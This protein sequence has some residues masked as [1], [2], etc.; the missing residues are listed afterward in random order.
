MHLVLRSEIQVR[1]LG[2]GERQ[3]A[4]DTF[5]LM[6]AV[7]G[8]PHTSLS[9]GY[10]DRLLQRPEMW[11]FAA[12]L[13]GAVIGGMT[14]HTLMMTAFEGEEILLYDI[15]VAPEY[16]RRGAG[17][18]LIDA[19]RHEASTLGIQTVFVPADSDDAEAIAFYSALGGRP[20]SV[21][22]FEFAGQPPATTRNA[23]SAD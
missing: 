21:T 5:A 14:A 23:R 22:H 4:R 18:Q 6:A 15:A 19:L 12:T 2:A 3:L 11:V 17:R 13:D 8:E 9:D 10:V 16:Q 7:F 1:R 20:S